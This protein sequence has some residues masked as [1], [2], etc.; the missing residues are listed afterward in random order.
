[1]K[2][3]GAMMVDDHG[4]AGEDLKAVAAKL[5]VTLPSEL[6]AEHKATVDRLTELTGAAFDSLCG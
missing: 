4:K 3:F 2:D 6:D 5:D 1:M